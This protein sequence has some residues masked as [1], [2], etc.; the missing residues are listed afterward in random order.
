MEKE[1]NIIKN[2]HILEHQY[3]VTKISLKLYCID[4][5]SLISYLDSLINK[6]NSLVEVYQQ[7][8]TKEIY[9]NIDNNLFDIES[10]LNELK[11][12]IDSFKITPYVYLTNKTTTELKEIDE[13]INH[14]IIN[15]GSIKSAIEQVDNFSKN[16]MKNY[17][18]K[19]NNYLHEVNDMQ[20]MRLVNIEQLNQIINKELIFVEDW[21]YIYKQMN[22]VIKSIKNKSINYVDLMNEK[23]SFEL[24]YLLI[25]VEA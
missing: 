19:V 13:A 22:L 1:Q 12:E 5:A 23:F 2:L 10:Y 15:A 6:T 3:L 9:N 25:L 8:P 17:V 16:I 7:T 18:T 24:A 20:A 21:N 11:Y 4:K 14:V